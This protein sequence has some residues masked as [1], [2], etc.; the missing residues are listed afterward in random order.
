MNIHIKF[1]E[2]LVAL[3]FSRT[4]Q[5]FGESIYEI[6]YLAGSF[7]LLSNKLPRQRVK[8]EILF[9]LMRERER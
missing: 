1:N 8:Q 4:V 6:L 2:K 3:I 7:Y 9:G 5:W